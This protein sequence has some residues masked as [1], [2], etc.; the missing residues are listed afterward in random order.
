MLAWRNTHA[1]KGLAVSSL[2]TT[3]SLL[4]WMEYTLF[5]HNIPWLS[6][7]KTALSGRGSQT[8]FPV[9]VQRRPMVRFAPI[10][11]HTPS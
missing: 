1:L 7:S 8:H 2:I 5:E 9:P 4:F 10:M 3:G 6:V 11:R